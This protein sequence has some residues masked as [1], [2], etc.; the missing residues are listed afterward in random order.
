MPAKKFSTSQLP[1]RFDYDRF[2]IFVRQAGGLSAVSRRA[3]VTRQNFDLL[4]K[5]SPLPVFE[6]IQN[7]CAELKIPLP[8]FRSLFVESTT[9]PAKPK[10]KP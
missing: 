3:G 2:L 9:P 10:S 1:Y 4:K 7:L 8:V 5:N 6:S